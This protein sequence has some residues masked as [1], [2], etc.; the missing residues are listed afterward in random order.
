MS[1]IRGAHLLGERPKLVEP[2]TLL[3]DYGEPAEPVSLVLAGPE[4]R[5]ADP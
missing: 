2:G 5:I 4:D 1:Q 3:A